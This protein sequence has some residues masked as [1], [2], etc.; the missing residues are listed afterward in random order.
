MVARPGDV[1]AAAAHRDLELQRPRQLDGVGDIRRA[2][3]ARDQRR[4]LVDESVVDA[5]RV[6]VAGIGRLKE[7]T[8]K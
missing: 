8:G 2:V 6:V 4:P 7:L 5:P 3:A 1:V